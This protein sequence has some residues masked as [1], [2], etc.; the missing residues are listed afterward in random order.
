MKEIN[1]YE[2]VGIDIYQ[3]GKM[4]KSTWESEVKTRIQKSYSK[5]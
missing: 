5:C 2:S 3:V 4:K 1:K